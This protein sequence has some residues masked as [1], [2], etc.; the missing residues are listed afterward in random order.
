MN[1]SRNKNG[2]R[3][4]WQKVSIGCNSNKLEIIGLITP[5]ADFKIEKNL[6][7]HILQDD[8]LHE[9]KRGYSFIQKNTNAFEI[10]AFNTV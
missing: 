4:R 2:Y 7:D 8:I 10:A 9:L 5:S 1:K 6:H 3:Y